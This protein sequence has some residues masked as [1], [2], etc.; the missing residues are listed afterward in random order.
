MPI[1]FKLNLFSNLIQEQF[2][3]KSD[4]YGFPKTINASGIRNMLS[5]LNQLY[6]REVLNMT[7]SECNLSLTG[8]GLSDT[9]TN[10]EI[11]IDINNDKGYRCDSLPAGKN[12]PF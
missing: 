3:S 6:C 2:L 11:C 4:A 1:K 9:C 10:D 7:Q 8:C 5:R 12:L